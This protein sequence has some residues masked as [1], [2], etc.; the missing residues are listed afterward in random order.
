M[1][2]KKTG[3]DE[4]TSPSGRKFSRKQMR[5][6]YNRKGQKNPNSRTRRERRDGRD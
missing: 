3:P 4:Y 5:A 1:P 6:Y 2:F